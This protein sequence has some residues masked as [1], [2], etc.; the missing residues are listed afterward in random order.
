M[1]KKQSQE[2]K[3]I[4]VLIVGAQSTIGQKLVESYQRRGGAVW[5]T[6][7]HHNLLDKQ[8][9]FLD[10]SGDVSQFT[11]P[12][13]SIKTAFICAA[14][15]SQE[16]CRRNPTESR[17]VNVEG[18]VNLAKRLIQLGV[19]VVFI[20]SNLV[21]DGIKPFANANDPYSPQT[22]YGRQK[23]ETESE[24]LKLG[25]LI[26]IVRFSKILSPNF[27][28]FNDWIQNLNLG[29][30]ISPFWD[31]FMAP[32]PIDFAVDVLIKVAERQIIGVFQVSATQDISYAKAA[33]YISRKLRFDE[34]H[35][36]PVSCRT[37]GIEFAPL[38]TS[39]D[40][41]R[42]KSELGLSPPGVYE[43]IC[44]SK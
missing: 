6:T 31:M 12:S 38:H 21:F 35:I 39:L 41:S 34:K 15:T 17:Q 11:L 19:H 32:I 16:Q 27:P 37:S 2:V 9:S 40:I 18:T 4:G 24:L 5:E 42:L 7:R 30:N 22:E 43:T 20:S 33:L 25:D 3:K 29:K 14:V 44:Y 10:L 28:L 8:R 1:P 36:N 13:N 26:S 23:V